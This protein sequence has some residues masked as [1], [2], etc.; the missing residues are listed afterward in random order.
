MTVVKR[1]MG[2]ELNLNVIWEKLEH[3]FSQ[4]V[5]RFLEERLFDSVR[6]YMGQPELS[7]KTLYVLDEDQLAPFL[8]SCGNGKYSAV[9]I[10]DYIEELPWMAPSLSFLSI[11]EDRPNLMMELLSRIQEVFDSLHK[12][13]NTL[14]DMRGRHCP[15]AEFLRVGYDVIQNPMIVYDSGYLIIATT[16]DFHVPLEDAAWNR[17]ISAGFW[18]PEIRSSVRSE[19]WHGQRNKVSYYDTN[20]FERNGAVTTFYVNGQFLGCLFVQENFTALTKGKLHLIQI[21]ADTLRAE[22]GE[23]GQNRMPGD[24]AIDTFFRTMLLSNSH[25]YTKEFVDY[26][27]MQLGWKSSSLYYVLVFNDMLKPEQRQYVPQHVHKL[28]PSS[29]CLELEGKMVAVAHADEEE[30]AEAT[31]KLAELIRESVMKCGISNPLDSFMNVCYG[32]RQAQAALLMGELLDPMFWCYQYRDYSVEY[33]VSFA[34]QSVAIEIICHPAILLLEQE[35][36]TTGSQYIST[37]DA[38]LLGGKNLT[39][40]AGMM[41][42][43]RNTLQYR[44]NRIAQMTGIDYNDENEMKQ[45]YLSIRMLRVYRRTYLEQE[46]NRK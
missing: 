44:L 46:G 23:R 34:L 7:A 31:G 16:Q 42:V 11:L 6:C 15:I 2:M 41:H 36:Q 5:S 9:I 28:F 45:L 13:E 27:L 43:H 20:N 21:F 30:L 17:L 1:G 10:G 4:G 33:V 12:W 8:R 39:K 14:A 18:T 37:L 29:Y 32:Y 3:N 24:S 40:L 26:N 35:D 22:L 38:Y 25:S 19:G